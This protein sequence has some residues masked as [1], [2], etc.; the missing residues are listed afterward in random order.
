MPFDSS[1][2]YHLLLRLTER[3]LE[4]TIN[5]LPRSAQS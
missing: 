4:Q 1:L 2:A 5:W 3:G